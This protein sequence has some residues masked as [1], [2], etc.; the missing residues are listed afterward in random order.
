MTGL[1]NQ[2]I[3]NVEAWVAGKPRNLVLESPRLLSGA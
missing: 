1:S 3:D 2:L